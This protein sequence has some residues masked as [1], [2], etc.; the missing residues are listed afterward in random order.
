MQAK[1][2]A[3]PQLAR[4]PHWNTT[5]LAGQGSSPSPPALPTKECWCIDKELGTAQQQQ[6][7]EAKGERV[8]VRIPTPRTEEAAWAASALTFLLVVL[9]VAVLYT[10]LHRNCRRGLSLYWTT[11]SDD[12]H[13]TVAGM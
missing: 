4:G 7:K 13:E 8:R 10:R 1:G 9:T 5:A 2:K 12:G 6:R 3:V 11:S